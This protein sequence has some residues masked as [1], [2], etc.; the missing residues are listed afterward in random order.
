MSPDDGRTHTRPDG[1]I[2][3]RELTANIYLAQVPESIPDGKWIVHNHV[4]PS[5]RLNADGFRAWLVNPDPDQY[6]ACDC[7]WASEVGQHYRVRRAGLV[8]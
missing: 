2:E 6:E 1:S 8:E 5:L 3:C 4:R 7:R